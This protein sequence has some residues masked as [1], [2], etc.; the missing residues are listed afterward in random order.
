MWLRRK[1]LTERRGG[2][3]NVGKCVHAVLSQREIFSPAVV[4]PEDLAVLVPEILATNSQSRITAGGE[5]GG[6]KA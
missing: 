6:E 4:V 1:S 2:I 3:A 5:N